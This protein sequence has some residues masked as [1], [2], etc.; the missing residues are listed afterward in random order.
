[1]KNEA[2]F[3]L[4]IEEIGMI[5]LG[6][7]KNRPTTIVVVQ[8]FFISPGIFSKNPDKQIYNH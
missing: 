7:Y 6:I 8:F 3:S 5:K 1:M 4:M 2:S